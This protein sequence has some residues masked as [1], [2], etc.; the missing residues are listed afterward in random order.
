[1]GLGLAA[2]GGLAAL[3]NVFLAYTSGE[4]VQRATAS[5]APAAATGG[6]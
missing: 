6:H 3:L 2:V 1:M 5:Q 4:P